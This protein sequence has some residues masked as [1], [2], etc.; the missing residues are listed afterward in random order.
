MSYTVVLTYDPDY[1]GYVVNV[2]ALPGCVTEGKTIDE[3]LDMAKDAIGLY[4]EELTARGE[5]V[6]TE[7]RP[8]VVTTVQ[9]A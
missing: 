7:S 5:P 1:D 4:V 9:A 3:A 6:P 8:P 2:P